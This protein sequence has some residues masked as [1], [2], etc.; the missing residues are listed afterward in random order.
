ME[1]SPLMCG[2][3]PGTSSPRPIRSTNEIVDNVLIVL[4]VLVNAASYMDV[5][6]LG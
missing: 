5:E 1:Q 3:L 2:D 4:S 6:I